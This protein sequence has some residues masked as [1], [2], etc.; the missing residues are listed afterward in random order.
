M[1][2]VYADVSASNAREV[3]LVNLAVTF[4]LSNEL[5][6]AEQQLGQYFSHLPTTVSQKGLRIPLLEDR[7]PAAVSSLL[8]FAFVLIKKGR[9]AQ[10][11]DLLRHYRIFLSGRLS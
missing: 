3:F 4:C 2:P 10:A 9:R 8:T 7:G 6:K 1:R 11:L 5:D